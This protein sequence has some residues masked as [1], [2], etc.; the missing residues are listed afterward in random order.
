MLG[1]RESSRLKVAG[2]S[3]MAVKGS[4]GHSGCLVSL[5]G[6]RFTRSLAEALRY[7]F[8]FHFFIFIFFVDCRWGLCSATTV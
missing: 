4:C 5:E 1:Y 6:R 8:S 2:G 7:V 3:V